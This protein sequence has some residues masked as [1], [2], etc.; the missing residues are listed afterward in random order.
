MTKRRGAREPGSAFG[1]YAEVTSQERQQGC[2]TP[3]LTV[4]VLQVAFNSE[5]RAECLRAN[6]L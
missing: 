5:I 3:N 6:I 2:R 4:D 1:V